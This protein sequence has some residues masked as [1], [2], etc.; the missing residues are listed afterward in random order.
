LGRDITEYRV[1]REKCF[2]FSHFRFKENRGNGRLEV[3]TARNRASHRTIERE[4]PKEKSLRKYNPD[5]INTIAKNPL[6]K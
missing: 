3:E 1:N 5:N 6:T 4:F 2:S